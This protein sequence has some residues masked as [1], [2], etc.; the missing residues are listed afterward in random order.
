M[1]ARRINLKDAA[2]A[3][4]SIGTADRLIGV[5]P[6][7]DGEDAWA[8]DTLAEVIARINQELGVTQGDDP[9]FYRVKNA[10]EMRAR[11]TAQ[12]TS[13]HPA[14]VE[15]TADMNVMLGTIPYVFTAGEFAFFAPRHLN[16]RFFLDAAELIRRFAPSPPEPPEFTH[17][18]M[19]EPPGVP[20]RAGL[21]RRYLLNFGEAID[22]PPTTRQ[23]AIFTATRGYDR[24][25]QVGNPI[26]FDA[27]LAPAGVVLNLARAD[28]DAVGGPVTSGGVT[29]MP[30]AIDFL[31]GAGGVIEAKSVRFFIGV[32]AVAYAAPAGEGGDGATAAQVAQINANAAAVVKNAGDIAKNAAAITAATADGATTTRRLS[33]AVQAAQLELHVLPLSRSAIGG[34]YSISFGDVSLL[35]GTAGAFYEIR[36]NG[37]L[38][39]ARKAWD[40]PVEVKLTPDAGQVQQ[41]A[42]ADIDLVAIE[43]A[44]YPEAGPSV[45]LTSH[46]IYVP[47]QPDADGLEDKI[48]A[49]ESRSPS[50]A[51]ALAYAA[52]APIDWNGNKLRTITLTGNVTFAFTNVSPGEVMVVRVAQ[53]A[54]GGRTITWPAAVEWAGGNA[55]ASSGANEVD[56]FTLLAISDSEIIATA[57]LDVS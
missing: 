40:S 41:I 1:A 21:A 22:I 19:V 45:A 50:A 15:I 13:D 12:A 33:A 30:M 51:T 24:F 48:E 37:V 35:H 34:E 42:R 6:A 23:L 7:L 53:D 31:D 3:G 26:A 54:V 55:E 44:F 46:V 32:D 14:I 9:I 38:M 25:D 57:L 27:R 36:F 4:R 52:N 2:V 56:V 11:A 49:L 5:N 43:V 18:V 17:Q 16:P 28:V 29:W 47:I 10:A 20:D 39:Q 8:S